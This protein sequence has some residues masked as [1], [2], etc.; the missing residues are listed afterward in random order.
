MKTMLVVDDSEYM[1]SLIKR[2]VSALDITVIG[3]AED[4]NS[5]IEKFKE[6]KPDIVTMDLAMDDGDGIKAIKEIISH[7]PEA[8]IIVISSIA[9]QEP[10]IHEAMKAG[11]KVVIDKNSL[12]S[13][14][15]EALRELLM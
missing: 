3:D 8:K 2:Y 1:R 13:K 12:Q 14:L 6:L 15:V 7:E 5:G 4:G 11:A 9:G 10:V